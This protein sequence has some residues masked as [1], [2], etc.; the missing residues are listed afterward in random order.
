M[1]VVCLAYQPRLRRNVALKVIKP[2]YAE[3][4]QFR[5]RFLRESEIAASLEH[6]HIIPIYDAGED[7]SKLYLVMRYVDGIDLR[8]RI[9]ESQQPPTSEALVINRQVALALD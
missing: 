7:G 6:P 5:E 4:I 8:R 1:A 3:D 9:L 2:E